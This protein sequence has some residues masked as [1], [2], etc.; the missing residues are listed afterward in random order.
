MIDRHNGQYWV[1]HEKMV[2][3]QELCGKLSR[4]PLHLA[5]QKPHFHKQAVVELHPQWLAFNSG[6]IAV[7]VGAY[8]SFAGNRPLV[9]LVVTPL[10]A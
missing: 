5:W 9:P 6:V 1:D 7:V 8:V 2:G 10:S 4:S 3:Y